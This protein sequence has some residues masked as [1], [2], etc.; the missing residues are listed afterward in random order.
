[1]TKKSIVIIIGIVLVLIVCIVLL[2][3]GNKQKTVAK[4]PEQEKE[5]I[6]SDYAIDE[7]T[8]LYYIKDEE[9]RRDY[10]CEL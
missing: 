4:L 1:M 6:K 7:E 5:E 10:S 8:G 3:Q 2:M 9:T